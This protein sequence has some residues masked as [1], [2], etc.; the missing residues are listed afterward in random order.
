M[1]QGKK[2]IQ[3]DSLAAESI[4]NRCR[5]LPPEREEEEELNVPYFRDT[6]SAQTGIPTRM[7]MSNK[8]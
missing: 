3:M 8:N 4:D 5:A 6:P 7:K 1:M 2:A